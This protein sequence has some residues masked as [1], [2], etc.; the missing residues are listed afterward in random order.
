MYAFEFHRAS[1][2]DDALKQLGADDE[3]QLIAGGQ[4]LLQS[5]RQ[6]LAM[7]STLVD[8]GGLTELAGIERDGDALNIGAMTRHAE[9]AGAAAVHDAIPA[10]AVLAGGIGDA[11]VRNMGTL[12]GSIANNDPAADYPAGLVGL[13]ATV[14]TTERE[15][16]ADDF[17]TGMFETA[18]GEHE[19]I[20]GVRFPVPRRAG[21]VKFPQPAS[22]YVLVSVMVAETDEGVRVAVSGAGPC[23]FRV[24][25]MERALA[26]DFR[27][28]AL[29][30]IRVD[31]GGL[32][33]DLHATPEYRAHLVGVIAR[34]AVAA[35]LS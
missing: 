15:I 18:L 13:G 24:P 32:N 1:D 30:G 33:E 3:A 28:E 14:V 34:R 31:P 2:I 12:G 7:P 6:R 4:T 25:E 20:L 17:F 29:D 5:L 23:V 11:Q 8:L 19:L 10:L 22:R 26:A 35:A 9:V 27:P 21:Y 16:A